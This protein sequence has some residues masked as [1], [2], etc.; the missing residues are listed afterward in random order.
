MGVS[1]SR[2]VGVSACRRKTVVILRSG[3]T[4]DPCAPRRNNRSRVLNSDVGQASPIRRHPHTPTRRHPM[5]LRSTLLLLATSIT[6][7]LAA[8]RLAHEPVKAVT[9]ELTGA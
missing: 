9:A 2:R 3:A 4:K 7:S 6:A 5:H 1:S 8:P